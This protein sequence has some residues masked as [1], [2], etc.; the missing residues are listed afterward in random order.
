M[1]C[2]HAACKK[3]AVDSQ[4]AIASNI[5]QG[6]CLEHSRQRRAR[7]LAH[8]PH[9]PFA[10]APRCRARTTRGT[11]CRRVAC[12]G[13]HVCQ[14]HSAG[15]GGRIKHIEWGRTGWKTITKSDG[16]IVKVR[17]PKPEHVKEANRRRKQLERQAH[18]RLKRERECQMLSQP[19]PQ[20]RWQHPGMSET[21]A[22]FR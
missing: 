15:G 5:E 17:N 18:Q 11:P 9:N 22:F 13:T 2:Q 12:K 7:R 3:C 4:T 19:T 10:T 20:E 1:P 6:Y 14:V 21:E 16:A 8:R